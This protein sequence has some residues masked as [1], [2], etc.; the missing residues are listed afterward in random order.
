M[1][2][3]L[4][5]AQDAALRGAA[6]AR[7]ESASDYVLRHAVAATEMDLADRRVFIANDQ[8]WEDLQE[9]LSSPGMP[10]N[11]R[12]LLASPSVLERPHG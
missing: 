7:G 1:N 2:L 8:S 11:V 5:P 6:K 10:E 9:L 4:T 12:K 3:R